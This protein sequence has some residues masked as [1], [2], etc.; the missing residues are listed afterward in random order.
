MCDE[1]RAQFFFSRRYL[2]LLVLLSFLAVI[3][4][5]PNLSLFLLKGEESRRLVTSYEMFLSG[6]Y[7]SMSYLGTPYFNKPPL[8]SWLVLGMSELVGWNN[9]TIRLLSIIGSVG[10]AVVCGLMA[11]WILGS[12]AGALLSAFIFITGGETIWWHAW[13]GEID[14]TM[15]LFTTA[16]AGLQMA[17]FLSGRKSHVLASGLLAGVIF[18]FK[19]FNA[20]VFFVLTYVGIALPY[21]RARTLL[22]WEYIS[23]F[24]LSLLVPAIWLVLSGDI[25]TWIAVLAGEIVGRASDEG[26]SLPRR[27][28]ETGDFFWDTFKQLL[29]AS[30]IALFLLTRRTIV[31]SPPLKALV[32]ISVFNYLPCLAIALI[33][34][35]L[36]YSRY[37]LPISPFIAIVIAHLFIEHAGP[38]MMKLVL[39][40][41]F[42]SILGRAIFGLFIIP[43]MMRHYMVEEDV[44]REFVNSMQ[45]GASIACD[46]PTGPKTC[47][48]QRVCLHV[49]FILKSVVPAASAAPSACYLITENY[50]PDMLLLLERRD[51]KIRVGLYESSRCLESRTKTAEHGNSMGY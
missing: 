28:L 32:F 12:A 44:A 4:M 23:S 49:G 41:T 10:T 40:L 21:G 37:L 17:G 31:L 2:L 15:A 16:M 22:G 14:P 13:R 38:A 45:S 27:I 9:A 24:L 11:W 26:L 46:C 43:I 29:P 20:H 25:E 8:F 1:L 5:L 39:F 50:P 7:L 30:A 19:G 6:D 42:L 33:S 47:H 48:I 51:R 35:T 36:V 3:S 34:P 18:L